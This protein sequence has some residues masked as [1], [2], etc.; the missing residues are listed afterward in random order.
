[1][2]RSFYGLV[3]FEAGLSEGREIDTD[4]VCGWDHKTGGR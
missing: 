4:L 1:V 2:S 3:G